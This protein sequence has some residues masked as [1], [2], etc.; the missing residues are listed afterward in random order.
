M[1]GAGRIKFVLL[2][3]ERERGGRRNEGRKKWEEVRKKEKE[4]RKERRVVLQLK[5]SRKSNRERPGAPAPLGASDSRTVIPFPELCRFPQ[6]M[7]S[8]GAGCGWQ[9]GD[10]PRR[11]AVGRSKGALGWRGRGQAAPPGTRAASWAGEG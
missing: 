7:T 9:R 3:G 11:A 10:F 8:P 5:T 6:T 2:L 4:N 1:E